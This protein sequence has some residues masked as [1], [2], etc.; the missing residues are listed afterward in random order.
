MAESLAISVT[1]DLTSLRAQLAQA[2]TLARSFGSQLNAAFKSGAGSGDAGVTK[3][4][5]S[6]ASAELRSKSLRAELNQLYKGPGGSGGGIAAMFTGASE[7]F[8]R[9]LAPM[10]EIRGAMMEIAEAAGVAFAVERVGEWMA[11]TAEAGEKAVNLASAVGMSTQ[12]FLEFSGAMT[13]SGGDADSASRTI[14]R[15]ARNVGDALNGTGR[16]REAFQALG[17]SMGQLRATG[18]NA[19]EVLK[20]I[21]DRANEFAPTMSRSAIVMALTGRGMNELAG[22]LRGGS[23]AYEENIEKTRALG[24]ANEQYAKEQAAT[25]EKINAVKVAV[26]GLSAELFHDLKPAFDESLQGL[27]KFINETR[28][29]A[30]SANEFLKPLGGIAGALRDITSAVSSMG[31]WGVLAGVA[32]GDWKKAL[33]G[34]MGHMFDAPQSKSWEF[35]LNNTAAAPKPTAP[36]MDK[37]G[38]GNKAYEAFAEEMRLEIAEAQGATGRINAIYDEWL[39]EAKRVFGEHS[40]EYRQV[41]LDEV[42]FAKEAQAKLFSIAEEGAQKQIAV[43]RSALD[44]FKSDMQ[45]LVGAGKISPQEAFGFD[46]QKIGQTKGADI[47]A[48]LGVIAQAQTPEQQSKAVDQLDTIVAASDAAS[49]E[50]RRQWDAAGEKAA[51]SFAAPFRS[52]FDKLGSGLETALTDAL[53]GQRG[54]WAKGIEQLR[55]GTI[56]SAVGIVGGALSKT[57]AGPLGTLLGTSS[58]DKEGNSLGVGDVLGNKLGDLL[59][60]GFKD[61]FNTGQQATQTG[62]LTTIAANTSVM[63]ASAGTSAATGGVSAAGSLFGGAA[64][65]GSLFG[66]LFGG[67]TSVGGVASSVMSAA[68][69][70]AAKGGWD[71][72][73]FAGGGW[74][75]PGG[76]SLLHPREMVLPSNLADGVRGMVAGGGGARGGDFNFHNHF[77]P[78]ADA[79]AVERLMRPMAAKYA[80]MIRAAIP[81]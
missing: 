76:L 9:V 56:S 34:P 26:I 15:L 18:G 77:G 44:G 39:A 46:L 8:S 5:E 51:E 20:L 73:S 7:E 35:D 69:L 43:N 53:T 25:G 49:K 71:V 57:A 10:G 68:S 2:T 21:I 42:N 59:S 19:T 38:G 37:A 70:V 24:A 61:L 50:V 40:K 78:G 47:D 74:N 29:A 23:A 14:E 31:P 4:A 80:S 63:A 33:F 6:L 54:G 55:T 17:I 60:S 16:A 22:L 3:L 48:Q 62:L 12:E 72:P 28:L 67:G 1:A 58:T 65:I 27:T 45:D 52:A 13:L 11:K 41:M 66:N 32:T 81:T 79:P 75:I 36:W 64:G 30:Q